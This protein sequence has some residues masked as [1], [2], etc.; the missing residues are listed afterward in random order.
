MGLAELE[1]GD[2]SAHGDWEGSVSF[3]VAILG[4][5]YSGSVFGLADEPDVIGVVTDGARL[6]EPA[7][8]VEL[9]CCGKGEVEL[10]GDSFEA[11]GDFG[12][13]LFSRLVGVHVA[14]VDELDVIDDDE[15]GSALAGKLTD[16]G[17]DGIDIGV[18]RLDLDIHSGDV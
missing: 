13:V 1:A 18:A 15:V 14:E 5:V 8:L 6:A 2:V 17:F 9:G 7:F 11:A 16:G 12:D 4:D 3:S 10:Q